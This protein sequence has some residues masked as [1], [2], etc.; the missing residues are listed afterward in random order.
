MSI[1]MFNYIHL[2]VI[3]NA[4]AAPKEKPTRFAALKF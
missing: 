3:I 2:F 1:K 4:K